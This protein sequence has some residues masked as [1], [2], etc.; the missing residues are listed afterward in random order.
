MDRTADYERLI[1]EAQG[2]SR[3][4]RRERAVNEMR[5]VADETQD[6]LR[7]FLAEQEIA[8]NASDLLVLLGVN[9]INVK[10]TREV[11]QEAAWFEGVRSVDWDEDIPLEFFLDAGAKPDNLFFAMAS[12][13]SWGVK[14]INAPLVWDLG[15]TGAGVLIG[16]IRHGSQLQPL[17]SCGS[18]V[19]R[20]P[21]LPESRLG[22]PGR[23]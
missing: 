16:I 5:R 7:A 8:G 11:I 17:G 6:E 9:G 14:K 1:V 15:I 4:E 19:G 18:H 20:K 10:A 12:D 22:L 13:T 21:G 2:L 3:R 23:G